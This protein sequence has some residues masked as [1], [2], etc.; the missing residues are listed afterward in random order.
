MSPTS[1]M[2]AADQAEAS[3]R[4]TVSSPNMRH[5]SDTPD[6][7]S[8]AKSNRLGPVSRALPMKRRDNAMPRRP[9]GTLMKKIHRQLLLAGQ[10][11]AGFEFYPQAAPHQVGHPGVE[12]VV[13]RQVQHRDAFGLKV[14][15]HRDHDVVEVRV[16]NKR[17]AGYLADP[18]AVQGH[19]RA[20]RQ[21]GNRPDE[22][23]HERD[24]ALI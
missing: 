13:Q 6:N 7:S 11:V 22:V 4:A 15:M 2:A 24:A 8:P 12:V 20:R 10:E 23:G 5:E 3:P 17:D 1:T 14:E 9:I 19:R 18:E 21:T 16:V